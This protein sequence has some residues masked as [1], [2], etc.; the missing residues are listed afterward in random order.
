MA[1]VHALMKDV[2]ERWPVDETRVMAS[3]FSRG[4]SMVWNVACYAGELFT[5]FVPIAGGFWHSTPAEC[6]A[7]PVNMR[8][9][10]GTKD[11]VVAYAEIGVYNSMPIS[12]GIDLYLDINRLK[13][14]PVRSFRGE[15]YT[16][17]RWGIPQ[18]SRVIELCLHQ[19]GHSIPAEWVAL[20]FDWLEKVVQKQN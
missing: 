13:G 7:G 11:K 9:I 20:G 2:R 1:Y 12:D 3:G 8:H 15:A 19:G 16:C 5:G 6:P 4:A 17:T 10:H 14:Q 18:K